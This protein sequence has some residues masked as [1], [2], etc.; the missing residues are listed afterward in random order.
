MIIDLKEIDQIPADQ[1]PAVMAQLAAAQ[2]QL[3]ARLIAS[4]IGSAPSSAED[5]L[6]DADQV[7]EIL[8]LKK[9]K[10][11]ELARQKEGA[12]PF[13]HIGKYP[14][15]SETALRKWIAE[16]SDKSLDKGL[17]RWYSQ[18]HDRGRAQKDQGKNGIDPRAIGGPVRSA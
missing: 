4:P 7:A 16:Q 10:V 8:N 5:R 12:P 3:A 17:S 18:N 2:S 9:S 11:Y 14:R 1:I 6:L 13:F 15:I